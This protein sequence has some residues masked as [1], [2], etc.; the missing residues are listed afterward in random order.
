MSVGIF[1][2]LNGVKKW[3]DFKDINK[4]IILKLS[5]GRIFEVLFMKDDNLSIYMFLERKKDNFNILEFY[6]DEKEKK[7]V[8]EIINS[9]FKNSKKSNNCK[10]FYYSTGNNKKDLDYLVTS[11]KENT[12][13]I[14]PFKNINFSD[15]CN[16]NINKVSASLYSELGNVFGGIDV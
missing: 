15:D 11:D 7:K 1:S 13:L 6:G 8:M 14:N 10:I 16:G 2:A 3:Y 9:T 12:I 4:Y 5:T